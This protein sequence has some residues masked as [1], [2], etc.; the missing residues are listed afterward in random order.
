MILITEED[1]RAHARVV[2]AHLDELIKARVD[3]M[4]AVQLTQIYSSALVSAIC[5]A[6]ER[7]Q[8]PQKKNTG[9]DVRRLAA[10]SGGE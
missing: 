1:S 10:S 6:L 3:V 2:A 9:A 8:Q 5:A 7:Q 4:I